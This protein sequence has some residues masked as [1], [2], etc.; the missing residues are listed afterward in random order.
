[1]QT[2]TPREEEYCALL[3]QGLQDKQIARKMSV[4]PNSIR[5]YAQ[6]IRRKLDVH[7]RVEV[8]TECFKKGIVSLCITL[9]ILGSMD[10]FTRPMPRGRQQRSAKRVRARNSLRELALIDDLTNG[11]AGEY[12]QAYDLMEFKYG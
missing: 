6:R 2:L 3:A 12:I 1:M 4:T 11:F 7:N 8:V 9:T 10:D 5:Q